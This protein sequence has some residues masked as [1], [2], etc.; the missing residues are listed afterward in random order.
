MRLLRLGPFLREGGV[1]IRPFKSPNAESGN[2]FSPMSSVASPW[3]TPSMDTNGI[4]DKGPT[5]PGFVAASPDEI[6]YAEELRRQIERRYLDP[7]TM[8]QDLPSAASPH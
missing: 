4:Q 5:L 8:R 3:H 6:R 7:S 1:F 2:G